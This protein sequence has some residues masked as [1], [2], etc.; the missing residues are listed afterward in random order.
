MN[1]KVWWNHMPVEART[2]LVLECFADFFTEGIAALP[3][4]SLGRKDQ[5]V[6]AVYHSSHLSSMNFK[7]QSWVKKADS[8]PKKKYC[9]C[10]ALLRPNGV[11]WRCSG[12]AEIKK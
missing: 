8:R 2:K 4:E 3:W 10:G 9:Q 5:E 6:L 7:V 11:C 1:P 12:L